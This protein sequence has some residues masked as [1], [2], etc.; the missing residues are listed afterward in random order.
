MGT[1]MRLDFSG[2]DKNCETSE[3]TPILTFMIFLIKSQLWGTDGHLHAHRFL[4]V[5]TKI[6]TPT[7]TDQFISFFLLANN[8]LWGPDEHLHHSLVFCR[9][10]TKSRNPTSKKPD[11]PRNRPISEHTLVQPR[12]S[13]SDIEWGTPSHPL[14]QINIVVVKLYSAGLGSQR[15]RSFALGSRDFPP[16]ILVCSPM[17]F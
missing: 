11:S 1:C 2:F 7:G 16:Q 12:T 3:A 5:W 4:R 13:S 15:L 17:W 6:P 14:T 9:L 10:A 8:E